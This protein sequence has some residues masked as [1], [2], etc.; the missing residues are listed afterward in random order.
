MGGEYA[1]LP[2]HDQRP[3][4]Y[5]HALPVQHH[6][7]E[8]APAPPGQLPLRPHAGAPHRV[9]LPLELRRRDLPDRRQHAQHVQE[10]GRVVGAAERAG[11]VA[12]GEGGEDVGGDEG[13]GEEVLGGLGGR[14]G[15][16]GGHCGSGCGDVG[17]LGGVGEEGQR[18]CQLLMGGLRFSGERVRRSSQVGLELDTMSGSLECTGGGQ[19]RMF[20]M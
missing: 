7:Y 12:L 9:E 1:Q 10:P 2:L 19:Q 4:A 17:E 18:G 16:V 14:G 5:A 13:R 6:Q 3:R 11:G 8:V 20:C 15:G